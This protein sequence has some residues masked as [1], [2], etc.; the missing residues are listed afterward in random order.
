[1]KKFLD[2]SDEEQNVPNFTDNVRDVDLALAIVDLADT[3][4]SSEAKKAKMNMWVKTVNDLTRRHEAVAFLNDSKISTADK[5]EALAT[6]NSNGVTALFWAI[7]RRADISLIEKMVEIGGYDMVLVCNNLKESVLHN[8]VFCGASYEV[9]R[10][11]VEAGAGKAGK[12]KQKNILRLQDRLGNTP[13][14]YACA[15]KLPLKTIK[16]LADAGGEEVLTIRNSKGWVPYSEDS[17]CQ[18]YLY[19]IGGRVYTEQVQNQNTTMNNVEELTFVDLLMNCQFWEAE[20][21]LDESYRL[22]Q[23]YWKDVEHGG[24][25]TLCVALWFHGNVLEST[26]KQLT[27]LIHRMIDVGGRKLLMDTNN[28][29]SNAVHYAAF[30]HA[31]LDIMQHIVKVTGSSAIHVTNSGWGSTPLHDACFRQAPVEVIEFLVQNQEGTKAVMTRNIKNSTP[32]DVLLEADNPCDDRITALTRAWYDRDPRCTELLSGEAV[33]KVLRWADS[34]DVPNV[35]SN[36][37]IKALLNERFILPRYFAVIMVDFV[38]QV[39]IALVLSPLVLDDFYTSREDKNITFTVAVLIFCILWFMGREIAQLYSSEL[40]EYVKAYDNYI[41]VAQI[42]LMMLTSWVLLD[43]KISFPEN[44]DLI[45]PLRGDDLDIISRGIVISTVGIAWLELLFVCGQLNYSI[46]VFTFA[47]VKII[48]ALVPFA[49]TSILLV[50]GFAQMS[51]IAGTGKRSG[52]ECIDRDNYNATGWECHASSS[53]FHNFAMFLGQKESAYL[54]WNA[55]DW[56]PEATNNWLQATISLFFSIVV[57][58]LLLNILIA[59]V[60]NV[61][62]QT[63]EDSANAFWTT[64]LGFMTEINAIRNK[65][66]NSD[67]KDRKDSQYD[68]DLTIRR[69]PF[70]KYDDEWIRSCPT[71]DLEAFFKWWYYAWN[72]EVPK[73]RTRLYY[74]YR[75]ASG[76][77]IIYP[78]AAFANVFFGVKYNETLSGFRAVASVVLSYT[79]FAVGCI[80]MVIA[81]VVGLF[82]PFVG[83]FW[84]TEMKKYLFCGPIV[85]S[86]GKVESRANNNIHHLSNKVQA[87]EKSLD[88]VQRQNGEIRTHLRMLQRPSSAQQMMSSIRSP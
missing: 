49:V 47:F 3:I 74:F 59:V 46:S 77:D 11:I 55:Y 10:E 45:S 2:G 84:P 40:E 9:F 86:A 18:S 51:F 65:L 81:F 7:R 85:E 64:R 36:N 88:A 17:I 66:C 26:Q 12:R 14:H 69:T 42:I 37:F 73:F 48:F 43:F 25:T 76:Q 62:S 80:L 41:D 87:L 70:S 57:G 67:V 71:K 33:S 21:R 4:E 82:P 1:M 60:S 19:K 61:F 35:T 27:P 78:G 30:N 63:Q 5:R 58:I 39:A 20:I 22:E 13:L 83:L 72:E 28:G 24:L 56:E 44:M 8:A 54:D 6:R 52:M 15:W 23:L 75:Y 31:S 34:G 38:C 50:S 68:K 79:H 29:G 53:F 16:Y 32:L